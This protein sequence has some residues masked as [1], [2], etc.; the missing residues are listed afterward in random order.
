MDT[1]IT[2]KLLDQI[3]LV[4]GFVSGILLIPE[5]VN[6]LSLSK[7][8]KSI[9]GRLAV[10]DSWARRFPQ[11]F[12]PLSWRYKFT[13]EERQA[14]EPKTAIRTLIFSIV[15]MTILARGIFTSSTLLIVLGLSILI[16]IAL[17][18]MV[19]HLTLWRSISPIGLVMIFIGMLFILA[20]FTPLISLA[21]VILLVFRPIGSRMQSFFSVHDILRTF[22]TMLAIILFI[23]SNTLQFVATLL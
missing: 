10:F 12:Y 11:R 16:F 17:G 4:F 23:L 13:D 18:N 21:R 2:A 9:E 15:W 19:L 8:Q 14:R 20:V 6:F 22:L 1:N 7:V 5:F 3:G